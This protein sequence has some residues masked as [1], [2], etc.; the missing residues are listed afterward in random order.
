MVRCPT[1]DKEV[2]PDATLCTVCGADAALWLGRGDET[3][4]PYTLAEM[5]QA[6]DDGRVGE[7]DTVM[8]GNTAVWQ[9]AAAF[10]ADAG[11]SAPLPPSPFL[12]EAPEAAASDEWQ[13]Q[14]EAPAPPPP[15][16][17]PTPRQRPRIHPAIALLLILGMFLGRPLA[18]YLGDRYAALRAPVY[19]APA[20]VPPPAINPAKRTTSG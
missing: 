7:D 11:P 19:G 3:F 20:P 6:Q 8:V 10:L 2:P 17:E 9:P 14:A 18:R 5:Q 4:G 13:P 12:P 16:E 1:C 15:T